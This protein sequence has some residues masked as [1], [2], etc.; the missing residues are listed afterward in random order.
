MAQVSAVLG[1]CVQAWHSLHLAEPCLL[2][3]VLSAS[4]AYA[5][6]DDHGP[7]SMILDEG[8]RNQKR[9]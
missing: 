4:Y 2:I 8:P 7:D 6:D 5:W 1:A 3:N 9:H